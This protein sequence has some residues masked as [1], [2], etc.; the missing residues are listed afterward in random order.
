MT[1]EQIE[2][3]LA[4]HEE[5]WIGAGSGRCGCGAVVG[6]DRE[7]P[8]TQTIEDVH[9]AHV[10]QVLAALMPQATETVEEQWVNVERVRQTAKQV[11]QEWIRHEL[12]TASPHACC[13]CGGSGEY[14]WATREQAHQAH[15]FAVIAAL[16]PQATETV[17]WTVV[18]GNGRVGYYGTD[19]V[20][21]RSVLREARRH[22]DNSG[23]SR[24]TVTSHAPVVGE[25]E[26]VDE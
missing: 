14:P 25:W 26:A 10:A 18:H 22:G 15:R 24:R 19:E 1:P 20:T 12:C 6:E 16:M 5:L 4:E 11:E 7:H 9:R 23:I 2:Q 8:L 21:A 3:A 17:E 13:S